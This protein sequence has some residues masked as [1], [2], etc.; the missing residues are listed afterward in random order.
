MLMMLKESGAMVEVVSP[1]ELWDPFVMK[2]YGRR[3][4]GEEMQDR[5]QFAKADLAFLSGESL[6][7]CWL[8]PH[9]RDD[10]WQANR[11]DPLAAVAADPIPYRGP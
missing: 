6:P 3:P 4:A 11:A 1:P 7:R 9:Y 5:E 2:I 8:N 10:E